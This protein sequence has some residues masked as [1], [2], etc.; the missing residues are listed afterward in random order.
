MNAFW[1]ELSGES[2]DGPRLPFQIWR[3]HLTDWEDVTVDTII[4]VFEWEDHLVV[5]R[6]DVHLLPGFTQSIRVRLIGL[7]AGR[8]IQLNSLSPSR[9]EPPSG[10]FR[11]SGAE[12]RDATATVPELEPLIDDEVEPERLGGTPSP[13]QSLV[14]PRLAPDNHVSSPP[15]YLNGYT[16]DP[17]PSPPPRGFT[18][19][20]SS[21]PR[22]YHF[23]FGPSRS[24]SR[25][26]FTP[27]PSSQPPRTSPDSTEPNSQG[28]NDAS[29]SSAYS[30]VLPDSPGTVVLPRPRRKRRRLNQQT[31][32]HHVPLYM[33]SPIDLT[34]DS[35]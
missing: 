22:R 26:G 27:P 24:P 5:R 35:D 32:A 9:Q 25:H 29:P 11:M 20:P 8:S 12:A 10:M 1:A 34:N 7:S 2:T 16:M 33:L 28:P 30:V 17:L 18:P 3:T 23:S 6:R 4:E 13:A 19:P 21:Q 31:R 14:Q 15:F